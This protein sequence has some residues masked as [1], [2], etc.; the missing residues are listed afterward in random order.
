MA[1]R[2]LIRWTAPSVIAA[3]FFTLGCGD[4]TP[5]TTDRRRNVMVIDDGFDPSLPV[6]AGKVVATYSTECQPGGTIG[7]GSDAGATPDGGIGFDEVKTALIATLATADD[8]C[9]L[10]V[11]LTPAANPFSDLEAQ[12]TGFNAAVRGDVL[13]GNPFRSSP[14]DGTYAAIAQRLNESPP[15]HGTA[16]SGVVATD[17]QA[18]RMVLVQVAL[19]SA[20]EA[21]EQFTCIA[22]ADIDQTVALLSDGDVRAAYLQRPMATLDRDLSDA[23]SR[24][25]IGLVSESFGRTSRFLLESLQRDSQCPPVD[26]RAYFVTLADLEAAYDQVHA[27]PGVLFVQAAG[28]DSSLVNGP[29]DSIDCRLGDPAHLLVGSYGY[30][31]AHSSFSNFGACVE[32]YAPGEDVIA[33]L[34]GDWLFPLSGTSFSTP[35]IARLLSL[36]AHIPFDPAAAHAALIALREPNRNILASH[37]PSAL[38]Y[39]PS[40]MAYQS[41]LTTGGAIASAPRQTEPLTRPALDRVL[42]P[43]RWTE[44]RR[45]RGR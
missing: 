37:F 12:R 38:L 11:D 36:T 7:D 33:P 40:R 26:L 28:N 44:R 42:W 23:R 34:P 1:S 22:Q 24:H 39:D 10:S 21:L 16:T 13:V 14:F 8:S 4:N 17:D 6:F 5:A 9:H 18:V 29:A 19:L 30:G 45:S 27:E 25:G 35:L 41:A 32:V 2:D 3:S 20:A 15:F 31:G 43:L